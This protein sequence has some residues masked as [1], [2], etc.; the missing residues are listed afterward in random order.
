MKVKL[1]SLNKGDRF[2]LNNKEY[3]VKMYKNKYIPTLGKILNCVCFDKEG[4]T[5]MFLQNWEVIKNI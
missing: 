5:Q 4:N 3:I 2:I 1:F